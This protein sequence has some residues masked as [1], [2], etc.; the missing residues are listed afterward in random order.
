MLHSVYNYRLRSACG[1]GIAAF[2]NNSWLVR[3]GL[4]DTVEGNKGSTSL[5]WPVRGG[6]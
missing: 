1:G 6:A 4:G 2:P 5:V 3:L